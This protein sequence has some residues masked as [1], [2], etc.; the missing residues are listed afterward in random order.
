MRLPERNAKCIK[1]FSTI[2]KGYRTRLIEDKKGAPMVDIRGYSESKAA[3]N[4]GDGW[5]KTGILIE[6]LDQLNQAIKVLQEIR[7]EWGE[8]AAKIGQV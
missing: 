5:L 7:D 4:N 2:V 8:H 6:D 3:T 1:E